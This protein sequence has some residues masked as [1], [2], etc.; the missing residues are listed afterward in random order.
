MRDNTIL[1]V[2]YSTVGKA[3]TP[4]EQSRAVRAEDSP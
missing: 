2:P 4:I 1:V 3:M